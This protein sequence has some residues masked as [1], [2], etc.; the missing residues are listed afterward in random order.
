MSAYEVGTVDVPVGTATSTVRSCQPKVSPPRHRKAGRGVRT[1]LEAIG[2][3][4]HLQTEA[5]VVVLVAVLKRRARVKLSHSSPPLNTLILPLLL[6]PCTTCN[7][8][9][10]GNIVSWSFRAPAQAPA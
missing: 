6:P 5:G 7:T 3:L 10:K 4:H 8:K 9:T 1:V 2:H